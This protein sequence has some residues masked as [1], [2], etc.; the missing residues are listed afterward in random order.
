LLTWEKVRVEWKVRAR[1]QR[2]LRGRDGRLLSVYLL[3]KLYDELQTSHCSSSVA[4][5]CYDLPWIDDGTYMM[6]FEQTSP[7]L[8]LSFEFLL[9]VS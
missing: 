5:H 3:Q 2:L 1:E 6:A 7:L 8:R 4:S 9:P